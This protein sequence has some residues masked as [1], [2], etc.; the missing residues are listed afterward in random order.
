MLKQFQPMLWF[1]FMTLAV[2]VIIGCSSDSP[3][4]PTTP[5]PTPTPTVAPVACNQQYRSGGD[6]GLSNFVVAMGRNAGTFRFD[7]RTFIKP[8]RLIIAYEGRTIFDTGCV[9]TPGTTWD[10]PEAV[11]VS[12][13]ISYAG[14]ATQVS[15]SV[16]ANCNQTTTETGWEFTVYCPQ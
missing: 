6:Q 1:I 2:G 15:V 10:D 9:T 14:T 11:A 3:T 4:T 13:I 7:Y 12:A 8:D 5:T 16:T